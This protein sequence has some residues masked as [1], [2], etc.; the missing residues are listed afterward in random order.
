MNNDKGGLIVIGC[1]GL[2]PNSLDLQ[3]FLGI[4][5]I[6]YYVPGTLNN[7]FQMDGNG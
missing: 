6:T 7:Q 1:F 4:S 2:Q 3:A 5:S